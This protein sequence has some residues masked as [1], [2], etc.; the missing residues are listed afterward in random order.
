MKRLLGTIGVLCLFIILTSFKITG[1]D[2]NRYNKYVNTYKILPEFN[3]IIIKSTVVGTFEFFV[4]YNLDNKSAYIFRRN[5]A[6][7]APDAISTWNWTRDKDLD[8]INC[9]LNDNVLIEKTDLLPVSEILD[10]VKEFIQFKFEG[11]KP[12]EPYNFK[13]MDYRSPFIVPHIKSKDGVDFAFNGKSVVFIV[14]I[15]G[16]FEDKSLKFNSGFK[17]VKVSL[18]FFDCIGCDENY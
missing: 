2:F 10:V 14:N 18:R 4:I 15:N 6:I 8:F 1:F 5:R 11:F 12:L 17:F 7:W 9:F 16:S 3:S 13:N